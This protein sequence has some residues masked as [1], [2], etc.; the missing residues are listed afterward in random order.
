MC[1]KPG[2]GRHGTS[3]HAKATY[4]IWLD[5]T[6]YGFKLF[7]TTSH[8]KLEGKVY[9]QHLYKLFRLFTMYVKQG[10]QA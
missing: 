3:H 5:C 9:G 8:C 4:Q 6:C 2:K 1:S 10:N 7:C